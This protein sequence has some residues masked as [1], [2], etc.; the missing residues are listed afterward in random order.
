MAMAT[1]Q[2]IRVLLVD[3]N[4][5]IRQGLRSLLRSSPN[6]EVIAEAGDGEE[7]VASA[8]TL[9]PAVVVMD[10]AM[11]RM[12]GITATRLIKA[13]N[14]EIVVVGLSLHPKNYEVHALQQAGAF[15]VLRKDNVGIN[16]C[17]AIE[18]AVAAVQ[19]PI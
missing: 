16:L 4:L 3:D 7:A 5:M 11:P 10:I 8:A 2:I 9:Q 12:D 18:R 6:V 1:A 19:P 17:G 14:P 13:Q 15:D